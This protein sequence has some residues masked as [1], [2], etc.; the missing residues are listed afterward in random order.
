MDASPGPLMLVVSIILIFSF[1][2]AILVL[3]FKRCPSNRVLVVY[4]KI[5]GERAARCIHGGGT[6]VV[7]L[8]QSYAYLT[9]EPMTID[10]ELTS[11]LSKK[12]IR[13]NVPSTFTVGISTVPEIMNNAAERLLGLDEHHIST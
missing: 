8:L 13:V 6:F 10:I 9:L 2:L 11:A 5:A 1:F 12:N 7:P 3:Q 4:G